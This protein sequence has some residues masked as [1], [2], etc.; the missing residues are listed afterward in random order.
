[1]TQMRPPFWQFN[2]KV[3]LRLS[4]HDDVIETQK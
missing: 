3:V 1:M 4:E 2:K